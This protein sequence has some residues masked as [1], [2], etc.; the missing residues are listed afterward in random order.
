MS[1]AQKNIQQAIE[2]IREFIRSLPETA[3]VYRMIDAQEN[4]LYVG[5]AKRLK[6]RV[7]NYTQFDRLPNRL[8]R[9]VARTVRMEV[10]H[11]ATE[12]EALL[13][14]STLIKK[15]QPQYNILLKDDKSFPYIYVTTHQNFPRALKY[16]G[17][18]KG[19]EGRFF[20]PYLS[21]NLVNEMLITLQKA[22]M[23]RNCS[24]SIFANRSRPCLQYHI[25]RC[26]APCVGYV[27][28]EEYAAQIQSVE[29]FLSGKSNE[30][31]AE[32]AQ[33]MYDAS[34]AMDFE[35]A[36]QWRDR[37]A[38]M[39]TMQSHQALNQ[40]AGLYDADIMA[41]AR[42]PAQDQICIQV[43][44][45]RGGQNYGNK[46][47]FPRFDS[48][49]GSESVLSAFI[50]Q[51]YSNKDIPPILLTNLIPD[52][53][54][55]LEE[56]LSSIADS[57]LK[58]INPQRG[59]KKA[60]VDA[61]LKNADMA[62]AQRQASSQSL[63]KKM[64]GLGDLLN[65]V[66]PLHRIEVYD[67]SHLSG[68]DMIGAMIVATRDGFAKNAYRKFNIKQSN[69]ADD[70]AMMREVMQRRFREISKYAIENQNDHKDSILRN[71]KENFDL[72]DLILIDGGK[73]QL[74]TVMDIL[75]EM[76]IL[77]FFKVVAVAKGID[78]NAGREWLHLDTGDAFQLPHHDPILHYIQTIRDEVHRFAIGAQRHKR[79][80]SVDKTTLDTIPN[81]GKVRKKALLSHFGS[82]KAVMDA[83]ITDLC[84]VDGINKATA[85]VIYHWFRDY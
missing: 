39:T 4:V 74:S 26:S 31:Q 66:H 57:P 68:T 70:Y 11:T 5:K 41:L 17:R 33:H 12:A 81:I 45:I 37:I 1:Y 52:E 3:G 62:L 10:V 6:R 46:S 80:M 14:E 15:L 23:I 54:D 51:F 50:A 73:G 76:G 22:F 60:L 79:L 38:A 36:A 25:K 83:S 82:A 49:E 64:D 43:F 8:K 13:L 78:R 44:F 29:K 27:T 24:D 9:M 18:H 65:L 58:I 77:G 61:A 7:L 75:K 55:V 69:A 30:I 71:L 21:A 85:E 59:S 32:F 35:K 16:R 48:E 63:A 47:Y 67:N 19:V 84:H 34:D 56:A 72:P 20:G 40:V 28:Q 53:Q 42:T 2:V